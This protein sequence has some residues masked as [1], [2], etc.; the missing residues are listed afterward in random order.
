MLVCW[1]I[2]WL[3]GLLVVKSSVWFILAVAVG[4]K[5]GTDL[6]KLLEFLEGENLVG[7]GLGRAG[8]GGTTT[9]N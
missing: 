5:E 4:G 2:R 1:L 8:G 3:I 6:T 9:T 7:R